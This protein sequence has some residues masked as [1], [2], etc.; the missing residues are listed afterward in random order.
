MT[1]ELKILP[2]YYDEIIQG[3]KDFEIRENDRDFKEEDIV[4]LKEFIDGNY[5]GKYIKA[6]I[7]YIFHGGS[8]GLKKGYC[9][10]SM[11]VYEHGCK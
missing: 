4:I 7:D 5:T 1:H 8:Y 10:F 11:R 2:K 6:I 3:K 9:V